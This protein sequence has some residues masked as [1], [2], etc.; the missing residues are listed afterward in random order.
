M[1]NVNFQLFSSA[2][3]SGMQSVLIMNILL[4]YYDF[5]QSILLNLNL[6]IY[7]KIIHIISFILNGVLDYLLLSMLL[8]NLYEINDYYYTHAATL[9][10]ALGHHGRSGLG[11][12]Q[13][14]RTGDTEALWR[15]NG[16]PVALLLRWTAAPHFRL[17]LLLNKTVRVLQSTPILWFTVFVL[18]TSDREICLPTLTQ[19]RQT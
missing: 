14:H 9:R 7:F 10:H 6:L 11:E 17:L 4:Y 12:C 1:N 8:T 15:M 19:T 16:R 18:V 5:F 3:T 2:G 13:H